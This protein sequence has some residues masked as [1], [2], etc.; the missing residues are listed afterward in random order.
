MVDIEDLELT[1]VGDV[2]YAEILALN[3][4]IAGRVRSRGK[5]I[6]LLLTRKLW[7]ILYLC[8]HGIYCKVEQVLQ[9]VSS[10]LQSLMG[11]LM[12]YRLCTVF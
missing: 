7:Q 6:Y 9:E 1:V 12:K 2:N 3:E 8:W 11:R 5:V 10:H 4:D